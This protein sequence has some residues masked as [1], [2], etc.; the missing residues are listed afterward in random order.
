MAYT[1]NIK[2]YSELSE[3]INR[4]YCEKNNYDFKVVK[5]IDVE[6]RALQWCKVK[7]VS[8]NMKDYNY[9]IWIDSDAIFHNHNIQL[10][11]F[12]NKSNKDILVCDDIREKMVV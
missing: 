9:V 3:N 1:D 6:G 10:E 7:V 5:N 4:K 2:S 11:S 8:E 12:I